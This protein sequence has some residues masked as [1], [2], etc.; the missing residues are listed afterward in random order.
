M[1][2]CTNSSSFTLWINMS[3]WLT[4]ANRQMFAEVFIGG[5]R[6]NEIGGNCKKDSKCLGNNCYS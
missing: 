1:L 6:I 3:A 2:L 4:E 5:L